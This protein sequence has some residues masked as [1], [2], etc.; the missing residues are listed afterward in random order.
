MSISSDDSLSFSDEDYE[1]KRD[2]KKTMVVNLAELSP[3]EQRKAYDTKIR[4]IGDFIRQRGA[5]IE[6]IK[7]R[8]CKEKIKQS[9]ATLK[10]NVLNAERKAT[11]ATVVP[12]PKLTTSTPLIPPPQAPPPPHVHRVGTLAQ[13]LPPSPSSLPKK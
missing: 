6:R 2:K 11:I 7:I 1:S 13:T 3:E 8:L 5:K 10:Y 12:P 9:E 4:R